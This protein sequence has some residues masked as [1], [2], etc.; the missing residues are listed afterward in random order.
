ML[1]VPNGNFPISTGNFFEHKRTDESEL[2]PGGA[3]SIKVVLKIIL[4]AKL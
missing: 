3:V 2:A 4:Y 1:S